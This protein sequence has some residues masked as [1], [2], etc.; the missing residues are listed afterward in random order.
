MSTLEISI[1]VTLA[2]ALLAANVGAS[3]R[4]ARRLGRYSTPY[5]FLIWLAP[6]VGALFVLAKIRP[7]RPASMLSMTTN[8]VARGQLPFWLTHG[9]AWA[10]RPKHTPHIANSLAV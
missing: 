10:W 8:P 4:V 6:V 9:L 2:I 7:A 3:I 5:V 1:L